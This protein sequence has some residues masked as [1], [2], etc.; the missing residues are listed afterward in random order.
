ML[1]LGPRQGWHF[2]QTEFGVYAGFHPADS[3]EAI[4][5]LEELRRKGADYLLFPSTAFWWL[6]FYGDFQKYL[7][8]RYA[9]I[10][11]EASCVIFQL[12]STPGSGFR[13]HE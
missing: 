3:K 1:Q 5:H 9:C 13:S 12:S 8:S 6:G 11:S 2:P 7:E 10:C 4:Y